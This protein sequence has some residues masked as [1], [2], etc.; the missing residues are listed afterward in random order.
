MYL[1]FSH[2]FV[3]IILGRIDIEHAHGIYLI[4][5]DPRTIV[6][7]RK[8]KAKSAMLKVMI[9]TVSKLE[10]DPHSF[11]Q[12]RKR[13]LNCTTTNPKKPACK[14][15]S[16]PTQ[17]CTSGSP[18]PIQVA[19]DVYISNGYSRMNDLKL[20][21]LS[22]LFVKP[23]KA[24]IDAYCIDT[25][26][27]VRSGNVNQLRALHASG[28]SFDCCN[29]FGE[30]LISMVC[31]KGNTE[32]VRF[33]VQEAK[34]SLLLCDDFGRT[35]LHDACWTVNP[36][37]DVMELLLQEVPEL[38]FVK[39]VRGHTPLHYVRKCHWEE[40]TSFLRD[41]KDLLRPKLSR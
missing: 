8:V 21:S 14:V 35:V 29:Q 25:I 26:K 27:A 20:S 1:T 18:S 5:S 40:W 3:V 33:L 15:V 30:S 24:Q 4:T 22:V 37:F 31:R 19:N 23:N 12:C 39:D 36:A 10:D 32:M 6:G 38:L 17:I 16:R 2:L 41:K 34:V 7:N 9:A 11:S 13:K 28:V